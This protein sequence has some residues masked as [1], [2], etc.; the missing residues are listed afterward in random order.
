MY[1][2]RFAHVTDITHR[3]RETYMQEFV[4]MSFLAYWDQV[5]ENLIMVD[6]FDSFQFNL[7]LWSKEIICL[8]NVG[9]H[10]LL[11]PSVI[12]FKEHLCNVHAVVDMYKCN[13]LH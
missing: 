7:R 4:D 10:V 12:L 9:F 8:F 5:K 2:Y 3:L 11:T 6:S 13:S 1:V